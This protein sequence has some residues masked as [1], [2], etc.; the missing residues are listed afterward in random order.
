MGKYYSKNFTLYVVLFILLVIV[1][2]STCNKGCGPVVCYPA[3]GFGGA[4][5]GYWA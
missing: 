5:P 2:A 1:G 3:Y 4:Y